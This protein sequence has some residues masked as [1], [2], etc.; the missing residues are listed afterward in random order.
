VKALTAQHACACQR[1]EASESDGRKMNWS[2]APIHQ[3]VGLE[4]KVDSTFQICCGM[5]GVAAGPRMRGAADGQM[6][7]VRCDRECGAIP[8]GT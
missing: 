2:T 6:T 4:W 5:A 3:I 1:T 8:F 7:L